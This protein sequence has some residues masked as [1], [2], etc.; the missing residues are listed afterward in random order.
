MWWVPA[1]IFVAC[2]AAGGAGAARWLPQFERGARGGL[3]FLLVCGLIAAAVGV[4]GLDIYDL[5]RNLEDGF[6]ALGV[7]SNRFDAETLAD[8][9]RGILFDAGALLG[10]AGI[11]FVLATRR[12]T[13]S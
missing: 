7:A 11:V 9:L 5:V 3:A 6:G 13:S 10:F 1:L 2:V 4:V 8:G 12:N